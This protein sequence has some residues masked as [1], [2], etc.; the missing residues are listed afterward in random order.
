[1]VLYFL[2]SCLC[3]SAPL[4]IILLGKPFSVL[5]NVNDLSVDFAE[6]RSVDFVV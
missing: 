2:E 4:E 1:M 5:K 6:K 3:F